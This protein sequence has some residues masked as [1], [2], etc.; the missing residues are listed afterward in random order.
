MNTHLPRRI[1]PNYGKKQW[2]SRNDLAD[3]RWK[4]PLSYAADMLKNYRERIRAS[5]IGFP[6]MFVRGDFHCHSQ[7]SD[8]TGTI[9][10][11]AK[12]A[13]AADLDFQFVTDHW[14][15]TQMEECKEYGLWWGQEPATKHHHI[16][17][18]GLDEAFIP[19]PDLVKDA[20][21]I[22]RRG[23]V[24]FIPHPAGYWP[25]TSYKE[26]QIESLYR[27]PSPFILEII[28]GGHHLT[29]AYDTFDEKAIEVWDSLLL[30]GRRVHALGNTDAHSPHGI[31]IVWNGVFAETAQ[32]E[33]VIGSVLKGHTFVSEAPLIY[34][35]VN[36]VP[37][38]NTL[39]TR[40][41]RDKLAIH[42][43]DSHGLVRIRV[44]AD[45]QIMHTYLLNEEKVFKQS[46]LLSPAIKR[47]VRVEC[48][49]IDGKRAYS[50][51]VY[52]SEPDQGQT[53][54]RKRIDP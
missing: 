38:G 14:G 16:C 7:H 40:H 17:V 49:S 6:P 35:D 28:N 20:L 45:G 29:N 42:A 1:M 51:P 39:S 26:E 19:K 32:Q 9:A 13:D 52:L 18:L 8:G 48:V 24:F 46:V 3:L 34:I 27:L 44:I 37:M 31:G 25:R 10:E 5:R 15:V 43:V 4:V 41:Q 30:T 22:E 11:I 21:E 12:M 36:G 47:Y 50:N 2:L 23:G 33:L 54:T 53:P